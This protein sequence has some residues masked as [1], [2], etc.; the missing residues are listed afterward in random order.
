[1]TFVG[2]EPGTFDLTRNCHHSVSNRELKIFLNKIKDVLQVRIE[3]TTS[4]YL[5]HH[6]HYSCDSL[7]FIST[8]R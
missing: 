4:A 8:A 2:F 7:L 1:M 5:M 6:S 3:L